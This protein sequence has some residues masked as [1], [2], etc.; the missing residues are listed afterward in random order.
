M[1]DDI[2]SFYERKRRQNEEIFNNFVMHSNDNGY[3]A[4]GNRRGICRE[5]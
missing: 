5:N 4:Y 1:T 3:D 2:D